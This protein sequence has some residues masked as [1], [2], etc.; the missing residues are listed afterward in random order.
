M[1]AFLGVKSALAALLV[2]GAAHAQS[3]V[4]VCNLQ[5]TSGPNGWIAPDMMISVDAQGNARV[6]DGVTRRYTGGALP[7]RVRKRGDD[8]IFNWNVSGAFDS[9]QNPIPTF[10]YRA[11]FDPEAGSIRVRGKPA[12]YQQ[13]VRGQGTCRTRPN[14]DAAELKRIFGG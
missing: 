13:S 14:P 7:A 12:R 5:Q 1:R 10:A 8:L 4:Y 9:K 3:A 2:A 11:D 6:I